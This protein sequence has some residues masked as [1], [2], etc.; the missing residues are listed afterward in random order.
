MNAF[1]RIVVIVLLLLL[2]ALAVA[3]LLTPYEL[4]RIALTNL[5][6]FQELLL[7]AENL[8]LWYVGVLAAFLV[9]LLVLLYLEIRRTRK[10]SA[11]IRSEGGGRA[12]IGV[13]SVMHS[14]EYRI[15]ELPGIRDVRP[16]IISRGK[17][18][19]VIVDLRTSPTVNV[20]DV[21]QQIVDLAHEIVEGQLGVKIR[22]RVE[23]NVSHEPFPRGTLAPGAA[24]AQWGEAATAA[25]RRREEPQPARREP[26][27]VQARP[28]PARPRAGAA[29]IETPATG[30]G[31]PTIEQAA[32]AVLDVLADE[33]EFDLEARD[34]DVLQETDESRPEKPD[35]A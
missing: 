8:Y 20:P 32:P 23:I 29:P 26:T 10:K 11:L 9:L 1:N 30:W 6:A 24:S 19:R 13:D 31:E 17:D 18:V 34:L 5:E 27:V 15:D 12:R 35:Q 4:V 2:A 7:Y 16:H 28:E 25:P 21:A 22:G 14:L 33:G 3:L